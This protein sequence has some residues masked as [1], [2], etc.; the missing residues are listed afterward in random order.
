MN[1]NPHGGTQTEIGINVYTPGTGINMQWDDPYYTSN[2]V[3]TDLEFDV[4][5]QAGNVVASGNANAIAQQEPFQTT[6]LTFPNG[7][8]TGLYNVVIKVDSGPAPGHVVFYATGDDGFSVDTKFGS[9]GG[10]YYPSTTGH[11]SGAETISVGAVPFW[12]TPAYTHTPSLDVN[13]PFSSTGPVLK[14]FAFAGTPLPVPQLLL[15]PDVSATDANNTSFFGPGEFLDTSNANTLFPANPPYPGDPTTTFA[16][17]T[18]ATNQSIPTPRQHPHRD[19]PRL[20]PTPAAIVA[21][22]KESNPTLTRNDIVEN[23]ITTTSS[24]DGIPARARPR[25][26]ADGPVNALLPCASRSCRSIRSSPA[27]TRPSTTSRAS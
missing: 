2:G 16:N 21:P 5:D 20:L 12:A 3:V 22:M 26:G 7:L 25:V 27:I 24:L 9:A 8:A 13:E 10:T 15:K 18:T 6:L 17:P 19:L 11:N 23:L 1:F 4:L 14:E